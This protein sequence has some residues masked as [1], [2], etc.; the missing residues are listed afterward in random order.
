MKNKFIF[1]EEFKSFCNELINL[2]FSIIESKDFPNLIHVSK[3]FGVFK[4]KY[5]DRNRLN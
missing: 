2:D 1:I 4:N 5:E 3:S